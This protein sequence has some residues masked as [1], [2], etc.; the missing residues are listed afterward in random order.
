MKNG[1][2]QIPVSQN[3]I[4]YTAFVTPDGYYEYVKMPFG[5][6]N[7]PSVFQRPISKAVKDLKFLR[8]YIDDLIIPC[9][10]MEQGLDLSL[11]A[12]VKAG[13]TINLKKCRFFVTSIEYL[14]WIISAD[15]VR[16]SETKIKAL[17]HSPIPNT[18]KQVRQFMGLA[19]YFRKF[20]PEFAARTA[21]ITK[22]TK[23]GQKWEWG[24]E[25]DTAR[26][27]IIEKLISEPI[28]CIF[29]PSLPTELHTDAS[30]I[31]YGAMLIQKHG[32]NNKVVAYFS[33]RI[34]EP[35]SKY[36][37][38]E[39]ETLA[40]YNSLKHFRAYL[41][42]IKFKIITDCNAIKSTM[43]KKGLSPRVAR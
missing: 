3:S 35:E 40:V 31:G 10:S 18:V 28:L 27:Y 22:L 12:L 4:K 25:Q 32:T 33:R 19:S 39:L 34:T 6:C 42:S 15:G 38:Y 8:V 26:K 37:S 30:S 24:D 14:G 29:Y 20:I 11:A 5:I 23:T 41:F 9:E 16:P 2:H 43:Y 7:G 1:F 36:T 21:C 13:F 17:V